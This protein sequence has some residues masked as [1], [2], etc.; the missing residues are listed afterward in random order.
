MP[1]GHGGEE[2]RRAEEQMVPYPWPPRRHRGCRRACREQPILRPG[3][4]ALLESTPSDTR[5]VDFAGGAGGAPACARGRGRLR[6]K[7]DGARFFCRARRSR[8]TPPRWAA[9]RWVCGAFITTSLMRVSSSV[10]AHRGRSQRRPT[11]AAARIDGASEGPRRFRERLIAGAVDDHVIA[12]LQDGK[13]EV[14]D[15]LFGPRMHDER[16]RADTRRARLG[17]F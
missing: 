5:F 15:G 2:L 1:R 9:R 14:E 7:K 10:R 8:R 3:R 16:L 6:R 4:P 17:P 12:A 13:A 11:R